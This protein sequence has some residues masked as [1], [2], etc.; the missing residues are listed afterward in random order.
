MY[1]QM[2]H[3]RDVFFFKSLNSNPILNEEIPTFCQTFKRGEIE[4]FC[5]SHPK[6]RNF[7]SPKLEKVGR[8]EAVART[9]IL[10]FSMD[11]F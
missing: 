4:H 7:P 6:E 9:S 5:L 11:L 8:L 1:S 2:Y 10:D 3:L